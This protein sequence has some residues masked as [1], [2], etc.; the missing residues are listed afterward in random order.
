MALLDF[1]QYPDY[2]MKTNKDGERVRKTWASGPSPLSMALMAGGFGMMGDGATEWVGGGGKV[3]DDI[4]R[5]GLLGVQAFQ[6][7]HQNLQNQRKD[8][9]TQANALEDQLIQNQQAK[10]DQEEAVR[11]KRLRENRDKSFPELLKMLTDSKRPEVQMAVPQLQLLYA[12]SRE[13]GVAAAMNIVSQLEKTPGEIKVHSVPGSDGQYLTQ[14]GKFVGQFKGSGT[15]GS[16]NLTKGRLRSSLLRGNLSPEDYIATYDM[17]LRDN[18]KVIDE[19]TQGGAS[20]KYLVSPQ[21]GGLKSKFDYIAD[22]GL[23]PEDFGITKGSSSLRELIGSSKKKFGAEDKKLRLKI[24]TIEGEEKFIQKLFKS[25]YDPTAQNLGAFWNY[26][27][28]GKPI[29]TLGEEGAKF[30]DSRS[31][32]NMAMGGSQMFGY[33]VSGAAVREDEM[34]R[35]RMIFYPYAGDSKADVIRKKSLRDGLINMSK[36]F[37]AEEISKVINNNGEVVGNWQNHVISFKGMNPVS[38]PAKEI[39]VTPTLKLE[40]EKNLNWGSE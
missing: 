3:W 10:R 8:F 39:V 11:L 20:K 1:E 23:K 27:V 22:L 14:G 32:E 35:M 4:G 13:K 19:G 37:S 17:L 30:A 33:L 34:L 5:G 40:V 26:V 9:Y 31:Y 38:P 2:A 36:S 7:G 6:Q 21:L 18:G 24:Q 12:T 15:S 28:T 16:D 29:P 25:G